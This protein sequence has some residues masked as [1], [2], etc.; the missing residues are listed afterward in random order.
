M[1]REDLHVSCLYGLLNGMALIDTLRILP[2]NSI[3]CNSICMYTL[4]EKHSKGMKQFLTKEGI[5]CC[6]F[7]GMMKTANDVDL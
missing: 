4:E 3:C 2:F 1:I 6:M 7:P 5:S